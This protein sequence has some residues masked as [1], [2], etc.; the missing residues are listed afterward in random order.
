MLSTLQ[1]IKE[2]K[3]TNPSYMLGAKNSESNLRDGKKIDF[4]G[5]ILSQF[6]I[7]E[8]LFLF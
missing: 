4:H 8:S 5:L 2:M 3:K 7:I 1:K 6:K